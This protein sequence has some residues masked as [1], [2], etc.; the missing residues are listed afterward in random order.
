MPPSEIEELGAW[1]EREGFTSDM[2][3]KRL[4]IP[5]M[6]VEMWMAGQIP[7]P[8]PVLATIRAPVMAEADPPEPAPKPPR[9]LKVVAPDGRAKAAEPEDPD[10][11][12]VWMRGQ[13]VALPPGMKPTTAK[14]FSE[15]LS[16]RDVKT[17]KPTMK[18]IGPYKGG[19]IPPGYQVVRVCR[20]PT[21][22]KGSPWAKGK[23]E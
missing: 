9:K 13:R 21:D 7:L 10:V 14:E 23:T 3:G 17:G 16:P 19:P 1:M 11:E 4:G 22:P 18:L 8:E 12:Y 15:R 6:L 20:G 5:A 2:A